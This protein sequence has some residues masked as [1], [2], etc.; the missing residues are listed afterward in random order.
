MDGHSRGDR[1]QPRTLR[2]ARIAL[3]AGAVLLGA[4]VALI[5]WDA[6][7]S[8]DEPAPVITGRDG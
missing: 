2:W 7:S 4:A 6:A 5:A 8:D 1:D 3:V